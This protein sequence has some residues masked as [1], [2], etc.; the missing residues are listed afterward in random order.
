[1]SLI[2]NNFSK[3]ILSSCVADKVS[4]LIRRKTIGEMLKNLKDED[5]HIVLI[6]KIQN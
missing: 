5:Q 1:M 2:K 4:E 3:K 6:M